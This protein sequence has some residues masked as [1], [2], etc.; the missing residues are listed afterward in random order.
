MKRKTMVYLLRAIVAGLVILCGMLFFVFLPTEGKLLAQAAPEY[1]AFYWPC[2]IF[3]WLFSV[4]V[5]A[6][7]F[8]AWHIFGTLQEKGKA[9]C[10]EN[11]RR[12][13]LMALL[14]WADAAIFLLGVVVLAVAGAGSGHMWFLLT[15]LLLAG[16]MGFGFA[17]YAMSRLVRESADMKEENELTV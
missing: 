6:M 13:R 8:P 1:A 9:F 14:S 5:F 10:H 3:A 15:P 4:P 17:C 11:A 12:F 2:L 16:L 7:A